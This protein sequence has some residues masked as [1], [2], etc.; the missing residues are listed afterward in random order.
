[1]NIRVV[2]PFEPVQVHALPSGDQWIGQVKWDGVRMLTYIEHGTVR[3]WNRNGREKTAQ[4]PELLALCQDIH[5]DS[6][7]LDG[8]IVSFDDG[9][10]SFY[11][12]MR[13]DRLKAES[14]IRRM[15]RH[16][17]VMY[18]VFDI[19][20]YNGTWVTDESL[21]RRQTL[22][23]DVVPTCE[24]VQLVG[25]ERDLVALVEATKQLKMEGVVVK[26]LRSPYQI[27]GKDARWQKLKNYRNTTAVVAGITFRDE[28]P[29][30]LVLGL[31]DENRQFRHIGHVGKGRLKRDEWK[32]LTDDLMAHRTEIPAF[33]EVPKDLR[34]STWWTT[35]ATVV[36]VSFLEWTPDRTLRHPV[37]LGISEISASDCTFARADA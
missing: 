25:S 20:F 10:P 33:G 16:A 6:C 3:L 7:V 8:E 23:R 34:G 14:S 1:M 9:K 21:Q 27:G 13:R 2:E 18:M 17:P 28:Q 35:V 15:A 22:L 11:Q 36:K 26:D 24:R 30:A 12:V 5:A 29:N 19:L 37:L 32:A 4:Y 31:Y